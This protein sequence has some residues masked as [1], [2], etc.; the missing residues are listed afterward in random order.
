MFI[1]RK[2]KVTVK[3]GSR[4]IILDISNNSSIT[5]FQLIRKCLKHCNINT[6]LARTYALFECISGI[7]TH[8]H[9]TQIVQT[10]LPGVK[11]TIRKYK[12]ETRKQQTLVVDNINR[13]AYKKLKE[14]NSELRVV[15]DSEKINYLNIIMNNE[16][17]LEKQINYLE[18]LDMM[19]NQDKLSD[20]FK[21]NGF[22]QFLYC[23]LKREVSG[24]DVGYYSSDYEKLIDSCGNSQVDDNEDYY[25][26]K[27]ESLV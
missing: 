6:D 23:K 11:F 21:N 19:D 25:L 1:N 15:D 18:K 20:G 14:L 27:Y 7:E 22:L 4:N 2:N 8:L 3:M 9:S 26:V 12:C 24:T 13:Y 16:K 5:S 17:K 10:T